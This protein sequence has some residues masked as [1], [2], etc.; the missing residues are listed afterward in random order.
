MEVNFFSEAWYRGTT[1]G[2]EVTLI[3]LLAFGLAHGLLG[4]RRGADRRLYWPGS[5]GL[6]LLYFR[7]RRRL[8]RGVGAED[9]RAFEL[10]K[11]FA[12]MLVFLASAFYVRSGASG[13]CCVVALGCAVRLRGRL[14]AEAAFHHAPTGWRARSTTPTASRCISA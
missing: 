12:S 4:G 5:L 3:E 13:R 9:I 6:M 1:R 2:V 10:S 11:I 14:G 8:G 7:L